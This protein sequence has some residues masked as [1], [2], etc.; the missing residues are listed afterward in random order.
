MKKIAAL[1][2][3]FVLL[4][5]LAACDGQ[6]RNLVD[7]E[8][9]SMDGVRGIVWEG[10]TYAPFCV[11][12]KNDRGKQIGYVDGDTNDRIS[13]YK[14]YPPEEWLVSWL[15]MDGG[16]IL[17]KEQSVVDIPDGLEAEY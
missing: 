17:L 8:S 14:G 1:I 13:E 9:I 7:M 15:P 10:R 4:F 3:L 2:L 12:S 6:R 16:A 11:I 5:S